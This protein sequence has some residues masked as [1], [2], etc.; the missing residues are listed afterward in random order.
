MELRIINIWMLVATEKALRI[1]LESYEQDRERISSYYNEESQLWEPLKVI[2]KRKGN[3]SDCID[4]IMGIPVI[5]EQAKEVLMLHCF[6]MS[7][8]YSL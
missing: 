3:K 7:I 2:T 1:E 4:F 5:T 6:M 8:G